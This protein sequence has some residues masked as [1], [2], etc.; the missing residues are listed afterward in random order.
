MSLVVAMLGAADL[1]GWT[2][3]VTASSVPGVGGYDVVAYFEQKAAR[4]GSPQFSVEY[5]NV[6]Y[7]FVDA[8]NRAT[9]AAAPEK[10][11]PQ[12]GGHCAW[13]AAQGHV[14][15]GDPEAWSVV[16][17][18]LYL[19]YSKDVRAKWKKDISGNISKAMANWPKMEQ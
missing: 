12:F 14:A 3:G 9:F 8:R 7:H 15:E 18:K 16:D 11:L 19:N 1:D 13:A 4:K 6:V 17:G 2:G 10:Y 5:E